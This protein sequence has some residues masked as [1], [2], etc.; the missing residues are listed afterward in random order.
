MIWFGVAA[1]L[2]IILCIY[3]CC[4]VASDADRRMGIDE[5]SQIDREKL[6][7]PQVTSV[8]MPEPSATACN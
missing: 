5:A 1:L 8:P 4:R 3:C 6:I 7:V 2:F